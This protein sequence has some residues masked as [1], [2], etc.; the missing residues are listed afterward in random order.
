EPDSEGATQ[1]AADVE[2]EARE[3]LEFV[4]ARVRALP[5]ELRVPLVLR[6]VEGWSNDDV[7][8][9]LGL[10]VAATKSRV[11]RARMRL[12]AEREAWSGRRFGS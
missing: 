1:A 11:R 7:A 10:S 9:M 3:E 2:A 5:A 8:R 4:A 6:D 12:R